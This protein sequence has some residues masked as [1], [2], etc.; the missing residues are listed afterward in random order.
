MAKKLSGI[1]AALL[2]SSVCAAC[3]TTSPDPQSDPTDS[4]YESTS[5]ESAN[6]LEVED[7]DIETIAIADQLMQDGYA[8]FWWYFGGG[9]GLELENASFDPEVDG[10][11]PY[12]AKVGRFQTIDELKAATEAVFSTEFCEKNFY[13]MIGDGNVV[14]E[15]DGALYFDTNAG[16]IGES[17]QLPK[18]YEIQSVEEDKIV[19]AA[20]CESY[21]DGMDY[22]FDVIL[23]NDGTGWKL[24]NYYDYS[25]GGYSDN[26]KPAGV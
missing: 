7:S 13:N 16:G 20:T 18:K 11:P 25:T 23:I 22:Q 17:Y 21:N 4:I 9:N 3:G 10:E 2:I 19:L 5:T 12:Y 15:I 26:V 24:D 6:T 14:A 8:V 1:V